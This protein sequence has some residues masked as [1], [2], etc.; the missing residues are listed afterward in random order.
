MNGMWG[1]KVVDQNYKSTNEIIRM[2]VN[3]SGKGANLLLNIGPQPNGQLPALALDR[4]KHLGEWMSTYGLD[5]TVLALLCE[6]YDEEVIDAEKNDTRVVLHLS[7]VVAPYKAAVLPL[8]KKLSEEAIKIC[9]DLSRKFMVDFDET[10][11]IGKRYR[12]Q[13]EIGT[14]LCI[15][16]DF[17]SVDDHCVT[18]RDRDTMKQERIAIDELESYIASRIEF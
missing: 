18:V 17:D 13:D 8:S 9:D 14:P 5:R 2:L 12:R 16:Y 15:T 1:Y 3:T 6:A 7:P 11:S 4:L 10:G